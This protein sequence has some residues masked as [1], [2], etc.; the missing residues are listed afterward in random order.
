M[1]P[2]LAAATKE[3]PAFHVFSARPN[4]SSEAGLASVQDTKDYSTRRTHRKSRAGCFT[5]KAKRVKCDEKKPTCSRCLRNYTECNWDKT[6]AKAPD[7]STFAITTLDSLPSLLKGTSS[8]P[9]SVPKALIR[10]SADLHLLKHFDTLSNEALLVG[11]A[12]EGYQNAVL[13]LAQG[14]QQTISKPIAKEQSDAVLVTCLMINV[15]YFSWV[16]TINPKDSWVFSKDPHRVSWLSVQQ[17]MGALLEQVRPFLVD[18]EV[19]HYFY[20]SPTDRE[21]V[22]RL[23]DAMW[24]LCEVT[25]EMGLHAVHPNPY[26][27]PLHALALLMPLEPDNFMKYLHF[28][29]RIYPPYVE[30]LQKND[31]RALLILSYWFALL[32]GS[33]IWWTK[34]RVQRDCLAICMLLDAFGSDKIHSLLDFP[35]AACGHILRQ[36]E[37]SAEA[38]NVVDTGRSM[39]CS[40]GIAT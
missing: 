35:A 32:G 11:P 33:G 15:H 18:T 3:T 5:C 25:D 34:R 4:Q 14:F 12:S 24:E 28:G 20:V 19:M 23:P 17:G 26:H 21:D 36:R 31:H 38:P 6:P 7:E 30:L 40:E 16:D 10:S 27:D 22:R 2:S 39:F 29:A 8:P 9:S 13:R 37:T 1:A